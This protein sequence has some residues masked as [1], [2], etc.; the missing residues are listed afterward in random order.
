MTRN[1]SINNTP[2]LT[3][4]KSRKELISGFLQGTEPQFTEKNTQLLDVYFQ[5]SYEKSTIGPVMKITKNPYGVIALGGYGR[6]EQCLFSDVDLLFLFEKKVMDEA[7]GLVKEMVYPLWDMGL[8]VGHATRSIKECVGLAKKD[9]SVL[10]SLLDA[11]FLC[12]M[13]NV[14]LDLMD[15]VRHK[16]VNGKENRIIERL[17]ETNE[18]R[19]RYFGDSSYRL[20]PN[21]KEGVG[22]L[23]DYHT[24]LWIARIKSN[25]KAAR[26]LEYEGYLSHGEYERLDHALDF[27]F[28]VRSRLHEMNGRKSDRLHFEHQIK[29][30]K[31][32][33]FED[34][35]G[36]QG[37]EQ[38]LGKLHG[39]MEFIKQL[40]R[41]FLYDQGFGDG[42]RRKKKPI[43]KTKV[44][45]LEIQRGM[46]SFNSP[47]AL[48]KR[49]NLIMEIFRESDRYH[50]PLS[51]E[52][53]RL[54]RE[55]LYII[56]DD[57]RRNPRMIKLFERIL[58]FGDP[59]YNVLDE[60]LDTGLLLSI[61]PEMENIQNRIQ[62]DEYHLYPVDKHSLHAVQTVQK[63]RNR[64]EIKNEPMCVDVYSELKNPA[65]LHWAVLLHDIGKGYSSEDHAVTGEAVV[66]TILQKLGFSHEDILTVAFLVREHLFLIK[67]ATRRDI[68]DEET[69][70]YCAR[71]VKD[72]ER[73]K[74][75]YLLTIADSVSTGPNA[76]N[77]WTASLL[78]N[79]F[80]KVF[81]MLEKGDMVSDVDAGMLDEKKQKLREALIRRKD[82]GDVEKLLSILPP[83]YLLSIPAHD[84]VGHIG[85]Y[86]RL[87]DHGVIWDIS[88]SG[89]SKTRTVTICAKDAPGLFSKI[90]GVFTLNSIDILNVQVF[91][92]RNNT[93]LDI[94]EVHPPPDPVFEEEKWARALMNLKAVI[95]GQLDLEA[96][97][98]V[99]MAAYRR[100]SAKIK[101]RPCRVVVDNDSSSFF[102]IIEVFAYDYSG[103]LYDVTH[104]LFTLG[105]DVWVAKISTKVDQVVD[106]FY[107]RDFDGQKVDSSQQVNLI[108][109]ELKSVIRVG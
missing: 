93:A 75:L 4:E 7:D 32:L 69:C 19:H 45:G 104:T 84:M 16:V 37:V 25:I 105:L 106:V 73:L 66:Q 18:E 92:W 43:K 28:L 3:L 98:K 72:P 83:R 53:K 42:T 35:D 34:R 41:V 100:A 89:L 67:T 54:V 5:E 9:I 78:R 49:P 31:A 71:R 26:D 52:A 94:F 86:D 2:F 23:R 79:L 61:I 60:M 81:E 85:I 91:T 97:L 90:A 48:L 47:E 58:V 15:Q 36:R 77:E 17:V 12:G 13:S 29:L 51:A 80:I 82:P 20:E 64:E 50:L 102:T 33:G 101:A 65:L 22:G 88:G 68:N 56:D 38:F 46:I 109:K 11:R 27:I 10:T 87:K 108:M 74:M 103:L 55:F 40:Y 30:A 95:A 107:V 96:A 1:D 99:K 76:W 70:L 21:L 39:E 63:W 62:F 24:L 57:F 59:S 44:E 8:D 6:K 14:Y